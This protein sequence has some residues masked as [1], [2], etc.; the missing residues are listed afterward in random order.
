MYF[1]SEFYECNLN[2]YIVLFFRK[3]LVEFLEDRVTAFN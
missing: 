1:N 2:N 3:L